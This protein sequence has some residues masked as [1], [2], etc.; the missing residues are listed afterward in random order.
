MK[1]LRL[2]LLPLCVLFVLTSCKKNSNTTG[3]TTGTITVNIDGTAQTFNVGAT[4]HVDNTGGFYTLSLIG[5]QSAS[6]ANSIIVEVTNSSPIVAGT[7][8]GTN[9]QA[10]MSYTQVS[11]SAVYQFDGSNNASNATITIKSIS[12]TNVQGTFS[13][14]LEIITG[15][16]TS[17]KILTNGTFNLNIKAP[18][19]I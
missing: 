7:Y 19:S 5:V 12:S 1:N 9:S 14:T 11:G 6:A 16:G 18:A 17:S 15:A 10:D 8:T 4:A 3:N 13:G 2:L